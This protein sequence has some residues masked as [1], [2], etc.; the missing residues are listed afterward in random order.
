MHALSTSNGT[1]IRATVSALPMH[2]ALP[3]RSGTATYAGVYAV[4]WI[5]A[6]GK[7]YGTAI[8]VRVSVL[9]TRA[10]LE[11]TPYQITATALVEF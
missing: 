1:V 9:L 2:H 3:T 8:R 6:L 5:Y 7:R 10:L 4:L 11:V